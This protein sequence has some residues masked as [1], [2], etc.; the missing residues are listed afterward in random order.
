VCTQRKAEQYFQLA[1]MLLGFLRVSTEKFV[2]ADSDCKK[3]LVF[4]M[5]KVF[6]K[7]VMKRVIEI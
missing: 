6:F 2:C 3:Q 5:K 4:I 1:D 7:Q